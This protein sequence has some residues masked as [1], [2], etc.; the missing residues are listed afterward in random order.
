MSTQSRPSNARVAAK[1]RAAARRRNR[2]MIRRAGAIFFVILF[3]LGTATTLFV[4]QPTAAPATNTSQNSG[5]PAATNVSAGSSVQLTP[6]SIDQGT[7]ADTNTQVTQL[8]KQAQDAGTS[9]KWTDAVSYYKAALGLT[10]GN[11]SIEYELGK[12]Y[13]QTKDYT[14][15][16]QHLQNALDQNPSATFA[17]DAQNLINTYKSQAAPASSASTPGS[18]AP[19]T[20]TTPTTK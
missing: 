1:R 6:N 18:V 5:V 10:T 11:A 2:E 17:S 13:I 14:S 15:A 4:F 12:A 9:G 16:V 3:A 7:P 19:T 8:V 20:A